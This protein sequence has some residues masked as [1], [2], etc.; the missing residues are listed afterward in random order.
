MKNGNRCDICGFPNGEKENSTGCAGMLLSLCS[1]QSSAGQDVDPLI[2]Y[3]IQDDI[4]ALESDINLLDEQIAE[5]WKGARTTQI[6]LAPVWCFIPDVLLKIFSMFP[7][8]TLRIDKVPW[9]LAHVCIWWGTLPYSSLTLWSTIRAD[10]SY[11]FSNHDMYVGSYK[12]P[13]LI[14]PNSVTLYN[15]KGL[16]YIV[17]SYKSLDYLDLCYNPHSYVER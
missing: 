1:G 14:I 8:D 11:K 16:V 10:S 7:V 3:Q 13:S 4:D 2:I 5:C 12:F 17:E 6:I 9:V 15:Q